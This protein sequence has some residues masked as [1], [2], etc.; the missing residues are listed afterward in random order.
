[1]KKVLT[2]VVAVLVCLLSMTSAIAADKPSQINVAY[3]K[4]WPTPNLFAQI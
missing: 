2:G 3:F 1:M 4:G